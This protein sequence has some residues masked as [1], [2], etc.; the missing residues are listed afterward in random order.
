MAGH[1]NP[2]F[3]SSGIEIPPTQVEQQQPRGTH[4]SVPTILWSQSE[5]ALFDRQY[6]GGT[7]AGGYPDFIHFDDK[8]FITAAQKQVPG[9]NST[10]FVHQVQPS[11]L[12]AL[13]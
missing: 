8:T 7:S 5:L 12:D 11:M 3:L 10:A 1:R 9:T 13:F 4:A 6:H 2:Y